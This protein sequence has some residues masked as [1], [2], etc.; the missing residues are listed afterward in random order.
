MPP[1]QIVDLGGATSSYANGTSSRRRSE[2]DVE[3]YFES[4]LPPRPVKRA[5][6]PLSPRA[7][8]RVLVV[9]DSMTQGAEG[10]FTWRYRIWEWFRNNGVDVKFVGPYI[11]TAAPQKAQPPAPPALYGSP[12]P[13]PSPLNI[14]GGYALACDPA[15][16]GSGHFSIWGRAAATDQYLIN[17][18]VK[19]NP[20]DLMLLMLGFNDMG[21]SCYSH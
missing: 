15:W 6:A 16:K 5:E 9:G 2:D 18:V 14:N 7:S 12:K 10:D 11:G 8:L 19:D 1:L 20:A 13:P 4:L 3:Q 17:Q 21:V